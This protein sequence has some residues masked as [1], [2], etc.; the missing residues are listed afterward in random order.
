MSE[1]MT[2]EELERQIR[3]LQVKVNV[4]IETLDSFFS[5]CR[6]DPNH[7]EF[8]TRARLRELDLSEEEDEEEEEENL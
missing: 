4:I 3:V 8:A 6:G 7:I 5:V 1:G 2:N